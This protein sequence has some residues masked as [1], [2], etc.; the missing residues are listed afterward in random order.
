MILDIFATLLDA[1]LI[2]MIIITALVSEH[3]T[4]TERRFYT[5]FAVLPIVNLLAIW[6]C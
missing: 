3:F 6:L 5:F 1:V 4:E 2:A